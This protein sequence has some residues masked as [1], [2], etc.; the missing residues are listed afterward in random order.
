MKKYLPVLAILMLLSYSCTSGVTKNEIFKNDKIDP[1]TRKT[2]S[3]LDKKVY[4][5]LCDNN[6]EALSKLFSDSLLDRINTD[7]GQ[8]FM[9]QIQK[10]IKGKT[11]SVFDEFYI[12]EVKPADTVNIASGEND[13]AYK[14]KFRSEENE[15]YLSMLVCGDSVNEVMLTFIYCNIK[16]TW[17]VM[18]IMGEDYSLAG[19]TA[20]AQYNYGKALEQQGDLIDAVNILG[21]SNHCLSPGGKIF[22]YSKAQEISVFSDSLYK[23][24]NAK[25]PLPYTLNEVSTT[26]KIVNIHCETYDHVFIPMIMYQSSIYVADTVRLKKENEE[27]QEKIGSIFPGILKTNKT[28]LYRAYN[29]LPDG[30]NSPRYYGYIQRIN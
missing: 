12:R 16:G 19:K 1:V 27:I 9:P 8:K 21:L 26:P 11:Y 3:D 23:K 2:L 14:I 15:T 6:Y 10:V 17:K 28:I 25:Y 13:N 4:N 20:I 30:K 24:A 29:D 18:N 7:F 22:K 5:Y